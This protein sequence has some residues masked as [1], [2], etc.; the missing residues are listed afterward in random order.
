MNDINK[1]NTNRLPTWCPGCGNFSIWAAIKNALVELNL[2]PADAVFV[3]DI[4]CNSN[5]YDALKVTAFEGL[6]GRTLP[7]ASGIKF[8]NPDLNVFT[9]AGDGGFFGEGGNHFIHCAR[10]NHDMVS[11][12]HD[13]Q[14]YALTTGQYSPTSPKGW[15]TKTSLEGTIEEALN[16]V[17]LAVTM[18]VSYVARGFAGDIP[19]L[20]KLIVEATKHK[21]YALIDVLQP[22]VTFNKLYTYQFYRENIYKLEE[23]DYK[24]DNKVKAYE[25]AFEWASAD[26]KG[27]IP[28]GVFYKEEREVIEEVYKSRTGNLAKKG[29]YKGDIDTLMKEIE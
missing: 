10:R 20:T 9:V 28:I 25:K 17:A 29:V 23:T 21:G 5:M 22:C 18:G 16:P 24:P 19:H 26:G 12:V 4:G 2:G 11:I 6:H 1:Y 27:K 14:F 15:K 7:V 8:A 13:N 3:F